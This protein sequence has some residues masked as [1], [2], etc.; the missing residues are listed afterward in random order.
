MI[1]VAK[2]VYPA[3]SGATYVRNKTSI[4]FNPFLSC[5]P[6]FVAWSQVGESLIYFVRHRCEIEDELTQ[7][8]PSP[9][10]LGDCFHGLVD[11]RDVIDGRRR[12][13]GEDPPHV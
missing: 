8:W 3:L 1:V 6:E 11:P 12:P 13:A 4:G 5:W 9:L 7:D 10:I 2:T